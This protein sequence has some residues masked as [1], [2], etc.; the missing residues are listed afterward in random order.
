MTHTD[1]I[2][3]GGGPSGLMA[4]IAAAQS[5]ARVT[6]LEKG[7]R[8]GRKLLISGGGRCNVTNAKGTEHILQNIPGN[9]RFLHSVF[10]QWSSDEII[11][12]FETRGVK[13]KEEDRGRL[14]PVTDR[15]QTVLDAILRELECQEVAIRYSSPVRGIL[16]EEGRVAGVIANTN[17]C[18]K[19]HAVVLATGGCSAPLTGSTGDGYKMAE[20][21]GHSVVTPYPT[22]VALVSHDVLIQEKRLQGI[23]LKS[24]RAL[25]LDERGKRVIIEEGDLLF[26]HFGLSGPLALRLSHSVVTRQMKNGKQPLRLLIDVLPETTKETFLRF[27]EDQ[28][29]AHPKKSVRNLMREILPERLAD[30]V[31]ERCG[32]QPSL[33]LR[34]LLSKSGEEIVDHLKRFEVMVHDTL[35]L[36]KSTV[37]GGGIRL[38]EVDPRSLQSK[39]ISGLFFAGEILDVHA[40]TGGY[41][42]TVAFTT[43]HVAGTHAANYAF[44][45]DAYKGVHS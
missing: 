23:S 27:F 36:A 24:V 17:E 44:H 3:I 19:A 22:S 20:E 37:T 28:R 14:F 6:I 31:I 30:V 26:T 11:R 25:L 12:F 39:Q 7:D 8:L 45:H 15:A 35:G 40:H 29:S 9:G 32:L 10:S 21:H 38:S 42:I 43:G 5:G 33:A 1:V 41:N 16:R 13:L 4:A 34:E 18:L 2:V